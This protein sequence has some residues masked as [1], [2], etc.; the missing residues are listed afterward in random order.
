MRIAIGS[1]HAGFELKQLLAEH[2]RRGGHAVDDVGTHSLESVDYPDFARIVASR[3]SRGESERGVLICGTGQ[4][5]AM[6]ANKVPGVRAACVSDT[7]SARMVAAHN[8]AR[9]L[10]MGQRV[11]GPGL[12]T[13]LLDAWMAASFEGGR[14]AGRVGKIEAQR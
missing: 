8:D 10:C 13:E 4:G 14:H 9:I 2:L 11:V 5:M 3:V 12:A 7:F 1:D 6:A